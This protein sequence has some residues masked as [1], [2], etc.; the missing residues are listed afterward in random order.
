MKKNLYLPIAITLIA[1]LITSCDK[2][3]EVSEQL[4]PLQPSNIDADAGTWKMTF[5]TA[6][7]QVAVPAP[8]EVTSDAY[9][10]ELAAIKDAQ[11]KLTNAQREAIEYWNGGGVL[12]WNQIFRDLVTRYNLPPAPRPDG[13]Y[14]A[15]DAENPFADPGFPFSN[16]PYAAR[17]YGY[18]TAAM[19]DA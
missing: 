4:H 19:Y 10:A 2:S 8:A 13:T 1:L 3:I 16:P 15:P 12:R 5:M 14:P 6:P 11:S 17:A 9:K 7:D 18:V